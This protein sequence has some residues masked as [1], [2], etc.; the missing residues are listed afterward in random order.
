MCRNTAVSHRGKG[1]HAHTRQPTRDPLLPVTPHRCT[2][3]L[4]KGTDSHTA[5]V[6]PA[7]QRLMHTCTSHTSI[8]GIHCPQQAHAQHQHTGA[9]Q[10]PRIPAHPPAHVVPHCPCFPLS[11]LSHADGLAQGSTDRHLFVSSR[12]PCMPPQNCDVASL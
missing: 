7:V 4:S 10:R 9:H 3:V 1:C 6:H 5:A 2:G 11:A 8:P 12:S